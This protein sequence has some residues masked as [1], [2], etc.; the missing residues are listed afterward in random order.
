[1]PKNNLGID[2]LLKTGSYLFVDLVKKM[3]TLN[4]S[5]RIRSFDIIFHPFFE[6]I[7]KYIPKAVFNRMT[8]EEF[9]R[10]NK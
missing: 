10:I 8:Q 9:D 4:P 2:A 3:L 6:D 5:K 1:M 7:S